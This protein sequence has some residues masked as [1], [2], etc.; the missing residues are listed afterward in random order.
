MDS[1]EENGANNCKACEKEGVTH[2]FYCWWFLLGL[3]QFTHGKTH[4]DT[5]SLCWT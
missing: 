4:R 1:H 3:N 5:S 2:N